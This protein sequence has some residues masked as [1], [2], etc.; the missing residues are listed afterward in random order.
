MNRPR[1]QVSAAQLAVCL[2]CRT[3]FTLVV[4]AM[5]FAVSARERES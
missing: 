1:T 5:C 2:L 3:W 4:A